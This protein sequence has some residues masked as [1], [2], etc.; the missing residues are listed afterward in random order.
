VAA[1]AQPSGAVVGDKSYDT[2][3]VLAAL[4]GQRAAAVILSETN[5]LNQRAY[6]CTLYAERNKIERFFGRL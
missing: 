2:G 5:R 6:A 1:L 4:A 3:N